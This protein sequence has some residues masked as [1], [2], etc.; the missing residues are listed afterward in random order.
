MRLYIYNLQLTTHNSLWVRRLKGISDK[1]CLDIVGW[2]RGGG[3]VRT[4]SYWYHF[5][6]CP[7]S[8]NKQFPLNFSFRIIL[9]LETTITG[10]NCISFTPTQ[11]FTSRGQIAAEKKTASDLYT[12]INTCTGIVPPT[13]DTYSCVALFL[14]CVFITRNLPAN[15]S[16]IKGT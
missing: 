16:K 3:E 6:V 12:T 8:E 15:W 11:F 2:Q 13:Y 14:V 7:N 10:T 9:C 4:S 1:R 5:I